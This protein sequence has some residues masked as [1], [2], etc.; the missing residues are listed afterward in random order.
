MELVVTDTWR[1]TWPGAS[2]GFLLMEGITDG[3]IT[4]ELSQTR[5]NLQET[6][7]A[8]FDSRQVVRDLPRAQAYKDYYKRFKKTYHVAA[9]LES[10]AVKG[11]D[12][13]EITAPVTAMFMAEIKNLILTAGH[14]AAKL[15]PPLTLTA[16]AGGEIL[17]GMGGR[18]STVKARDMYIADAQDILSV[19]VY[20]A[21]QR[22]KIT[23][24]TNSVLYCTYAPVGI[25]PNAVA[26]HMDDIAVF[27]RLAQPQATVAWSEIVQA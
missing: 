22:T 5:L 16:A 11:R 3:K 15:V 9:Q 19:V 24:Q 23:A 17:N 27:L 12:I 18:K 20:G 6:L 13:P 1:E 14:D 10:V 4:P 25:G 7:R 8:N 2:A 21:D 26:A